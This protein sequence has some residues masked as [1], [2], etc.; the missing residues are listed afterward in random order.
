MNEVE[1]ESIPFNLF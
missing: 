1:I